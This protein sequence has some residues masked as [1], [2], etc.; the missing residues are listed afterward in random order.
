[1]TVNYTTNLGL[2]QPVTG[3]E[4]GTWGDDVNNGLTSYFDI[5]IAGT[6]S[7]TSASFTS[8]ALTLANT[9]GTSSN[10]NISSTTTAQYYAIKVSGLAAN[11][12]I[13]A[14]LLSKTYLVVNLDS[15]YSVT[16]KAQGVLT[17]V[18]TILPGEKSLVYCSGAAGSDYIKTATSIPNANGS[19][20]GTGAVVLATSPTL[21]GTPLA[22]TAATST[23]TTQIATTAFVQAVLQLLYPVGSVYSNASNSTNPATLFGFGTWSL[24]SQGRMPI[25]YDGGTFTIGATGGSYNSTLPTHAHTASFSGNALG[26][27]QHTY[28]TVAIGSSTTP[29]GQYAIPYPAATTGTTDAASAGTPSGSVTVDAAGVSPSFTNLPPYIVVYIWQRIA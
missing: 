10:P 15:T 8:N 2:V 16:I 14:P 24:F 25:G 6:L 4:S 1:M 28:S 19:S 13:T 5:A 18:T 21:T 26:G 11:V 3:T 29:G 9:F 23:N 22:P 7:L 27:H 12:T 17:G 20:T